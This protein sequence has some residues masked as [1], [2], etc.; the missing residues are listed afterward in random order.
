[1]SLLRTG[2]YDNFLS[3]LVDF[4]VRGYYIAID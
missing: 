3:I 4:A 1:M 2:Q